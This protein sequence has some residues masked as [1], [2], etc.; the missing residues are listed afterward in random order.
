LN[1]ATE[2]KK[3]ARHEEIAERA[4]QI[5][6]REGRQAGHDVEYWLRAER[7]LLSSTTQR[8]GAPATAKAP[9]ARPS[10]KD[11]PSSS[12]ILHI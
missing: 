6:E 10:A 2:T 4:K 3:Q 11:R 12:R 7:E 5:W 1:A 8:T 9:P